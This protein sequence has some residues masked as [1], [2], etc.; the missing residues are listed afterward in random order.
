MQ[1]RADESSAIAIIYLRVSTTRQADK[2]HN[3]D[4]QRS[5][6]LAY[7]GRKGL[8]VVAEFVDRGESARSADRTEF[9]KMLAYCRKQHVAYLIVSK[10]DRFARNVEDQARE[11]SG[12][13]KRYGIKTR[14]A[15][16]PID[17]TATGRLVS[18]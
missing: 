7:C 2:A 4:T 12:L 6:C 5:L 8:Q 15:S 13:W 10:L 14:S 1:K 17:E 11:I 18:Q 9:Q 16:E 3:V